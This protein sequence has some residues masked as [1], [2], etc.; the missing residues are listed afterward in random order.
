MA[1]KEAT[2]YEVVKAG[3]NNKI[4]FVLWVDGTSQNCVYEFFQTLDIKK[5]QNMIKAVVARID[6]VYPD[7]AKVPNTKC[8]PLEN[9]LFELKGFQARIACFMQPG[10]RTIIGIYGITKKRDDWTRSDLEAVRRK[11]C[12]CKDLDFQN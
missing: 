2:Y 8:K 1:K 3:P 7:W 12:I 4:R 5:E 6:I 11:Y 9:K 10:T